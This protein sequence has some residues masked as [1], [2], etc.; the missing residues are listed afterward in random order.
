MCIRERERER[1]KKRESKRERERKRDHPLSLSLSLS[2]L[3]F[4]P[5]HNIHIT[6]HFPLQ[7]SAR[8]FQ[9][10]SALVELE[11]GGFHGGAQIFSLLAFSVHFQESS[12]IESRLLGDLNLSDE[13]VLEG[14][15]TLASLLHSEGDGLGESGPAIM[16][17]HTKKKK[18]EI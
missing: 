7:S 4:S 8:A 18:H 13:H 14:V 16:M 11:G 12:H 2:I 5:S 15:Y 3:F 9:S 1:E 17:M 6:I 10:I